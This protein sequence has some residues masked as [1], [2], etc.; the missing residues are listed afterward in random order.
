MDPMH[1]G[2]IHSI[3]I[4]LVPKYIKSESY[5]Q[6]LHSET[7]VPWK[8]GA[9]GDIYLMQLFNSAKDFARMKII[10]DKTSLLSLSLTQYKM[11][12]EENRCVNYV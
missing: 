9:M 10:T 1:Y 4:Q 3:N 5:I 6:I 2:S 12:S 7:I 11:S 8:M